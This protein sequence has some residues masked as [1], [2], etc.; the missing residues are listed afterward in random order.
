MQSESW[1]QKQ[2]CLN[3]FDLTAFYDAF[4]NEINY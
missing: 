1:N 2:K 3:N 4:E